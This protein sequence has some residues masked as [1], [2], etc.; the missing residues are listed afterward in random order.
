MQFLMIPDSDR[1]S[2][3]LSWMY[4]QMSHHN[5]EC[6]STWE[7]VDFLAKPGILWLYQVVWLKSLLDS[8]VWFSMGLNWIVLK[9][10]V[11]NQLSFLIRVNPSFQWTLR[12]HLDLQSGRAPSGWLW[13]AHS[14]E[15][16]LVS[17]QRMWSAFFTCPR[18]FPLLHWRTTSS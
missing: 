9:F 18:S 6:L 1:Y 17:S 2:P 11:H 5:F 8:V 4:Q 12:M 7:D 10:S 14:S 3:C 15:A 16:M 13:R